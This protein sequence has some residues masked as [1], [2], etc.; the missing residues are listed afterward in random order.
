MD[1]F[2]SL[3]NPAAAPTVDAFPGSGIQEA[4][5]AEPQPHDSDHDDEDDPTRARLDLLSAYSMLGRL[6]RDGLLLSSDRARAEKAAPVAEPPAPEND[7]SYHY[8]TPD[9]KAWTAA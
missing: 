5:M 4:E 3:E 7:E 9:E 2:V 1:S 6:E 8:K